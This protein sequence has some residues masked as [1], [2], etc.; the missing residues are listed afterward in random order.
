[1]NKEGEKGECSAFEATGGRFLLLDSCSG[2]GVLF[3]LCTYLPTYSWELK[4]SGQEFA[5][6][7]DNA[8]GGFEGVR[9][10][11]HRPKG[12]LAPYLTYLCSTPRVPCGNTGGSGVSVQ[13]EIFLHRSLDIMRESLMICPAV[14]S[15]QEEPI[16][17]AC[18][19]ERYSHPCL[20]V[21]GN[22]IC[23][24][25]CLPSNNN[26]LRL[27]LMTLVVILPLRARIRLYLL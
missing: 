20:V 27:R 16:R 11:S 3:L 22:P 26:T 2:F 18:Q 6:R 24:P 8:V 4:C 14:L 12:G 23:R 1:M 7:M 5:R 10:M 17:G 15:W 21:F 9:D 19:L 25:T 13:L